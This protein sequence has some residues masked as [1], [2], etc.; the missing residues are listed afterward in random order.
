MER[1]NDCF[2]SVVIRYIKEVS[3]N[4]VENTQVDNPIPTSVVIVQEKEN[5]KRHFIDDHNST[6]AMPG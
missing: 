2:E 4:R 5:S 3:D 6:A 1:K